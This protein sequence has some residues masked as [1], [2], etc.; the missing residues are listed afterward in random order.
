MHVPQLQAPGACRFRG[1]YGADDN[2]VTDLDIHLRITGPSMI[3]TTVATEHVPGADLGIVQV[4]AYYN[5]Q[6]AL[7]MA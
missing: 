6:L 2:A 5:G 4:C 7:T 1:L 3:L